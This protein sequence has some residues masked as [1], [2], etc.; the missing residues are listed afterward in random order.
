M[1]RALQIAST[2]MRAQERKIETTANNLANMNTDGFKRTDARFADLMYQTVRSAGAQTSRDSTAPA[3]TQLGLGTTLTAT[4]RDFAQGSAK[5]TGNNLDVMI[6]GQGFL[7]V[8]R[9][10]EVLYTRNG[11]LRT[12]N[13]GLLVNSDGYPL[14]PEIRIPE[15]AVAVE[16]GATGNVQAIMADEGRRDLGQIRLYAVTNQHGLESMG[17][18]LYRVSSD[19]VGEV[20]EGAPGDTGFGMVQQGFLE[21]ANVEVVEE[22]VA[23]IAGQ[24]AYE[25]NSK[26][27]QTTDRMLEEANRLR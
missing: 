21:T 23:M 11:A 24:R 13:D 3:P 1:S 25:A 19:A 12:N 22:M 9:N 26:V 8:L 7:G 14:E 20:R 5:H 2:G 6:E 27:I 18:N 4:V 16:I 17:K 10:N 15:D